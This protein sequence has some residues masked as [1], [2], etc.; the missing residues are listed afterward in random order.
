M[1]STTL[2]RRD[3]HR[4]KLM[5]LTQPP[6]QRPARRAHVW[7]NLGFSMLVLRIHGCNDVHARFLATQRDRSFKFPSMVEK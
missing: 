1:I 5:Y 6:R 3:M 7:G 4:K 2:A